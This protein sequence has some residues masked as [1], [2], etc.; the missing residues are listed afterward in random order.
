M[1]KRVQVL[2]LFI[3]FQQFTGNAARAADGPELPNMVVIL[4]D[5]MRWD[6]FGA[7]GH[8]FIKTPN[9]D[10]LARE[11]AS[12]QN[13]FATTPL[14]SPSRA[15]LLTGQYTHTHGITDNLDRSPL[16]HQ[17]N[18]F[19]A[20]LHKIGYE[21]AFVGK[22]HMGNDNSRRPGF[23][24]WVALEGQGTIT[25]PLLN[26]NDEQKQVKGYVTD[27]LTDFSLDFINKQRTK[28]FLLYLSEKA[29]HPNLL[30]RADGSLI[31]IGEGGFEPA[32]RHKGIYAESI[33][34]R[35]AN[36]YV[37]PLDKPALSRKIDGLPPLGL[38]TATPDKVIRERSEMLMSIDEGL[39]RIMKALEAK[40]LLNSTIIVFMSDHGYWY[41]EH[42]LNEERRLAY[43]EGI[44]IPMLMRYPP[45]I[46]EGSTPAQMALT[47]DLAPTLLELA[48]E[49]AGS[50]IQ[51][52]SL[53]S[54]FGAPVKDWRNSFLIEYYT[55]KV[56]P[57]TV[58]MGYKAIRT[59]QY[60]YI[61]YTDLKNMDELYDLEMDPYE[62]KN[63]SGDP[64]AKNIIGK[65][66]PELAKHLK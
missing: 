29:L 41:G 39:G 15:S 13:A 48:G 44:R 42:G 26:V 18:T 16:S 34:T 37:T 49:K 56:W 54:L 59:T 63:I 1:L 22:W 14:C 28:P 36:A 45:K 61:R 35:R 40:N 43:E 24:Y 33:F 17:L 64:R 11:G 46:R 31:N 9:I 55:D 62:L 53:V 19:P 38:S 20:R 60:K 3:A 50:H 66:E 10:R 57:R 21:T 52:R 25:D 58:N 47:I 12:F 51:G 7:A 8:P 5:D 4:V 6:E 2:I 65:L 27:I 23:S 30:Q 32:Q